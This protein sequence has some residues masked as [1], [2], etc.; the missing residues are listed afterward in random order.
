MVAGVV[1]RVGGVADG[2]VDGIIVGEVGGFGVAVPITVKV[3]ISDLNWLKPEASNAT[4]HIPI[5]LASATPRD[6]ICVAFVGNDNC[7]V[8]VPPGPITINFAWH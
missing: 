8:F 4:C 6:I 7:V 2:G 1:G 3:V 5:S